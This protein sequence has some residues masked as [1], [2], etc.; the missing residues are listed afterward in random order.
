MGLEIVFNVLFKAL[1]F[2]SAAYIL[3]THE[4]IKDLSARVAELEQRFKRQ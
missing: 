3:I 2:A 1:V 4:I